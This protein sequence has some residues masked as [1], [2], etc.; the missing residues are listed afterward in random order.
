MAKY[1]FPD[2][3]LWGSAFSEPQTE[4]ASLEDGKAASNWD[5]WFQIEKYR[6]F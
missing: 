4:G 1:K 2:Q 3:F 5:H 6:F